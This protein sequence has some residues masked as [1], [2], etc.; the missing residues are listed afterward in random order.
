MY[1][2]FK[3]EVKEKNYSPAN[4]AVKLNM[5]FGYDAVPL[6]GIIFSK[7]MKK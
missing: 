4:V 6:R 7:K 3:P 2:L 5:D 1:F